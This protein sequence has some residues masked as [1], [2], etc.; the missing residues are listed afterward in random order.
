LTL[1]YR[2]NRKACN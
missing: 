2:L 1:V